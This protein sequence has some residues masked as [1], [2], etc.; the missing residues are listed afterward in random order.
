M[1]MRTEKDSL[2][3][4]E[5]PKDAYYGV[6]TIRALENFPITGIPVHKELVLA[7]AEVKKA[8]AIAN[9]HTGML[10]STIGEAIVEASNEV[11]KGKF[12]K[13]F[14]VDS[15]QG[16]AGTSI[17]MNMNEVLANRA[18]EMLG[19][20]KGDYEDRKSTRLNSSHV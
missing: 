1:E 9:M 4:K 14:I 2:G 8:A 19:R 5:V 7:L 3:M 20:E 16:G 18:L 15:I 6:Q 17:N 11:I 10:A 13:Q 12:E